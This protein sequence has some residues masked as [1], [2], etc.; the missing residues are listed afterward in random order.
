MGQTGQRLLTVTGEFGRNDK[1]YLPFVCRGYNPPIL[2][3]MQ[4]NF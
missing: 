1:H 2:Q 4:R 3:N